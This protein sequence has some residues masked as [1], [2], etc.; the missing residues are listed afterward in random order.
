M[1]RMKFFIDMSYDEFVAKFNREVQNDKIVVLSRFPHIFL[2]F[3][4]S[5]NLALAV[6][7]GRVTGKDIWVHKKCPYRFM[8]L[9]R[10]FYGTIE[11]T[12]SG[13][14]I[15]GKFKHIPIN[16]WAYSIA[17]AGIF[18][19]RLYCVLSD[20]NELFSSIIACSWLL[21]GG[22]LFFSIGTIRSKKHEKA[23]IEYLEN[24]NKKV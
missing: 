16:I 10:V 8:T 22:V 7:S 15:E 23:T 12:E 20:I 13:I 6:L 5:D 21:F 2:P 17:L 3:L 9:W 19:W 24:F 1:K 14:C 11:L 4:S 18:I